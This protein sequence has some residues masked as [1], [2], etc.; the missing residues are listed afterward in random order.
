VKKILVVFTGGTIGSKTK[1]NI[2]DVNKIAGDELIQ[3]YKQRTTTKVEFD[4]VE[5][6]II[7]SE[8]LNPSHWEKLNDTLS[9]KNLD[10]YEG[11]IITHGTDTLPYTTAALSYMYGGGGKPIVFV[12]SNFGIENPESNAVDNFAGAVDFILTAKLNGV[13]AIYK[14]NVGRT[15]VY[16]GTRLLEADIS[17]QF[18]SYKGLDFGEMID[19]KFAPLNTGG[20]A[21]PAFTPL[22]ILVKKKI[23]SIHPYPGLDY[24]F[25]NFEKECPAAILHVLYHSSTACTCDEPKTNSLAVFA[26][27]CSKAEIGLYL[28][29]CH[30]YLAGN[31]YP[32]IAS[33]KEQGAVLIS[34]ISY[35]AVLTKLIIAYNQSESPP[36]TYVKKKNIYFE[37]VS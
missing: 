19:G 3:V 12:A 13:F 20:Y 32:S 24:D 6:F 36:Q 14:N 27:R 2:T 9:C 28:L 11:V 17:D 16:L 23:I 10:A 35:E 26:E 1:D 30:H 21:P 34:N 29:D 18:S 25:F 33:L 22:K 4:P 5:S 37:Y 7:L 8:D 15:M 31:V